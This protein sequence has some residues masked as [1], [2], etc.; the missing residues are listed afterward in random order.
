[1]PLP[2]P[3]AIPTHTVTIAGTQLAAPL[4]T[5]RITTP[6]PDTGTSTGTGRAVPTPH[7]QLDHDADHT[8]AV[9]HGPVAASAAG[10]VLFLADGRFVGQLMAPTAATVAERMTHLEG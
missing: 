5:T 7:R 1:M 3:T 8:G 6:T 10:R 9:T 2:A 4:A